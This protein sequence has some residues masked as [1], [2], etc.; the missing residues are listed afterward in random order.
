MSAMVDAGSDDTLI[1]LSVGRGIGAKID[2]SRNWIIQGIGGQVL[3]VTLGEVSLEITDG[4]Q[5]FRWPT[6]VGL[7]DY[8]D[9]NDEVVLVGHAGFF[10][11]F[12]V[13][14][15]GHLRTL[16]MEATP[17]FTGQNV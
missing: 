8:A 13:T 2:G 12:R 9:P 11:Y 5:T 15:D 7:V 4:R 6:K 10:D 1:P 3:T 17:A 14:F 16:E